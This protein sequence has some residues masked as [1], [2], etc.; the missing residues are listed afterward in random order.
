MSKITVNNIAAELRR[1]GV[2]TLIAQL[3]AQDLAAEGYLPQHA[4][5]AFRGGLIAREVVDRAIARHGYELIEGV[6]TKV[7]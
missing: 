5:S 4:R 2:P 7:R 6:W 1:Q 3:A